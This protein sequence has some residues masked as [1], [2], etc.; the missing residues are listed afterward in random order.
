MLQFVKGDIQSLDLVLHVMKTEEVDTVMHFAAQV[1]SRPESAHV[2]VEISLLSWTKE[3]AYTL[4]PEDYSRKS[5][6]A[7]VRGLL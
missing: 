2:Q 5:S 7:L 6:R 3:M 4:F 1:H